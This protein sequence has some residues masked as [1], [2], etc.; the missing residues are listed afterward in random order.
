MQKLDNRQNSRVRET[1]LCTYN[2]CSKT[3]YF[4]KQKYFPSFTKE[5][6]TGTK[7]HPGYAT[8]F[9]SL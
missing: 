2:V 5:P 7:M 6:R 3:G 8:Q 4:S 1:E 9:E